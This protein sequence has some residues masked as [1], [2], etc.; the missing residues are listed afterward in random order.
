MEINVCVQNNGGLLRDIILLARCGW[1]GNPFDTMKRFCLQ[2]MF[3]PKP[4]DVFTPG[5][6]CSE[7]LDAFIFFLNTT[8]DGRA[9][10]L[11][12]SVRAI[13]S[14]HLWR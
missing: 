3:P 2:P 13:V 1:L 9:P 7:G 6:G 14:G 5:G 4:L 8:S 12:G 10:K 11:D